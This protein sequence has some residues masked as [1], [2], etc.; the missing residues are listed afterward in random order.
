M[1]FWNGDIELPTKERMFEEFRIENERR[2]EKGNG[3]RKTHLLNEDQVSRWLS[4]YIVVIHK[5][6]VIIIMKRRIKYILNHY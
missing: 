3:I 4:S 6:T 5:T 1:K 2:M